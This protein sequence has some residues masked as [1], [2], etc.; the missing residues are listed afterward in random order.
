M[1][2]Q[3]GDSIIAVLVKKGFIGRDNLHIALPKDD[4]C[5]LIFI[6]GIVNSKLVDF[7]YSM[8][9][10]EKGEVLAQVKKQHVEQLPIPNVPPEKQTPIVALVEQILTAKKSPPAPL[11]HRGEQTDIPALEA[12]ID[13]L[14]YALYGLSDEEIVV[15]KGKA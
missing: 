9:N 5:N 8:M 1:V 13:R 4:N 2:R 15:V 7:A 6:L 3:T 11:S 12:E 14:V 10:P